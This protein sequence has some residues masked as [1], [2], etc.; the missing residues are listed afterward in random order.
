MLLTYLKLKH[1]LNI[2]IAEANVKV[3]PQEAE[4]GKTVRE[5]S[6]QFSAEDRVTFPT[7]SEATGSS[8]L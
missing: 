3:S 4:P 6:E 8:V 7:T 1:I 2:S 5:P